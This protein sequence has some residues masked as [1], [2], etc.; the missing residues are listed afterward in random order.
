MRRDGRTFDHKTLESIRLV[1][2]ERVR[3]GQPASF[4]IVSCGFNRATIYKWLALAPT[5]AKG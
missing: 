3:E 4:V 1:A 2:V 5:P